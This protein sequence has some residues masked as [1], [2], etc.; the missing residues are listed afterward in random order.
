M[1]LKHA[2]LFLVLVREQKRKTYI[3]NIYVHLQMP[4][5]NITA[6][7]GRGG[8]RKVK[9][10]NMFPRV[11]FFT[12]NFWGTRPYIDT[13]HTKINLLQFCSRLGFNSAKCPRL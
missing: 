5:P 8:V 2:A 13:S 7:W 1:L 11:H 9:L 6:I 3:G 12:K 10:F 4:D